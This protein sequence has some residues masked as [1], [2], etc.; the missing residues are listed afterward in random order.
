MT[1]KL[2]AV[3]IKTMSRDAPITYIINCKQK[4]KTLVINLG[5]KP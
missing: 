1:N 2:L 3:K 4:S 5:Q